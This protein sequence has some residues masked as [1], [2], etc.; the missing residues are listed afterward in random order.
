MIRI[1]QPVF[2]VHEMTEIHRRVLAAGGP[3]L[4]FEQPIKADGKPSDMPM[5]AN[6]FGTVERVACGLGIERDQLGDSA[7]RWRTCASRRRRKALPMR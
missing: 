6:L 7:R 1:R 2:V 4:L 3:A 5:L